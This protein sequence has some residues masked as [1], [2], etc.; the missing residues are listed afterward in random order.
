[1]TSSRID[2]AL[3]TESWLSPDT[4]TDAELSNNGHFQVIRCDRQSRGGG[5][6]AL[7]SAKLSCSPVDLGALDDLEMIAIDLSLNDNQL[8]MVCAYLSPTGS[9]ER[10][11]NRMVAY[12]NAIDGCSDSVSSLC[13]TGDFNLPN[14][15]WDALNCANQS[16]TAKEAMFL[17]SCC[18]LGLRQLV[19]TSTRKKS[20]NILDLVLCNDDSI[21]NVHVIANPLISDHSAISFNCIFEGPDDNSSEVPENERF[22]Y[23][24]G[25]YE[26]IRAN[27]ALVNWRRFFSTCSDVNEM[28]CTLVEYLHFLRQCFIPVY[29]PRNDGKVDKCIS[30]IS[31]KLS[32]E[33][34]ELKLI[35]LKKRLSKAVR[36]KRISTETRIAKTKNAKSFYRY[37][38]SRMKSNDHLY[39][40]RREDGSLTNDDEEKA[41]ILRNYF[42]STYPTEG[43]LIYRTNNPGPRLRPRDNISPIDSTDTSEW[44]ILK[45]LRKMKNSQCSTPDNLPSIFW[46]SCDIEICEALSLI[47]ER[48]LNDGKLPESFKQAIV[49]PLHKK[50]DKTNPQNKRN[51]SLT[52][53]PCKLFESIIADTIMTNADRQNLLFQNQFAYRKKY[54]CE[55]Q[56]LKCQFD[57]AMMFDRG[58]PFDIVYFDFKSAF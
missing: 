30:R 39:S 55:L 48:S 56:L 33:T 58:E 2:I 8:R 7:V 41:E 32:T 51:V 28:Y 45:Y 18:K 6:L 35:A 34:D 44:N 42:A 14:I 1:M 13:I 36:R 22:L 20:D 57:L 11:V 24:K 50:G 37:I 16:E 46:K 10:L 52:C 43:E 54:S 3:I 40:L 23:S 47:F 12:R 5:A 17:D 19:T 15:D 29:V 21:Q 25:D 31:V 53:S 26:S 9:S 49:V 27:L 4:V 38:A